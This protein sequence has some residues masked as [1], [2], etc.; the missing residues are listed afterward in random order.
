MMTV[1]LWSI[2]WALALIAS[3]IF[4]KGNPAKDWVQAALFIGALSVWLWQ[5]QRLSCR[6]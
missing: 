1:I 5:S 3:A 2:A 4:L 6:R